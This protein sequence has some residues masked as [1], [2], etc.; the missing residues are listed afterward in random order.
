[1]L[2]TVLS[3]DWSKH[4]LLDSQQKSN[5]ELSAIHDPLG[6]YLS[7]GLLESTGNRIE[8]HHGGVSF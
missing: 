6:Q 8:C 1:M 2:T 5:L 4:G 3:S 7:P